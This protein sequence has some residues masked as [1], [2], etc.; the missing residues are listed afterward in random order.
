MPSSPRTPTRPRRRAAR[1]CQTPRPPRSSARRRCPYTRRFPARRWS[2]TAA[3]AA[4][5]AASLRELCFTGARALARLLRARKVSAAELMQAFIAQIERVNPRVNAI[6]TFVPEQAL[7][8]AR[9]LDRRKSWDAPLAGLPIAYKDLVPTKG[10]RTTF[11]SAIYADQV[12]A[13]N[14]LLVERL[15]AVGAITIGKTNT[16]EFG[17]G[18]QTFNA[19]FGTTRN[20]YD[21]SKTCGGSSGGA[22]VAVACG[23]LPFADGSELAASLRNPGNFCN[24]ACFRPTPGLVPNLPAVNGWQTLS[25]AGPMGRTVQDTAFLLSAMAGPDPRSPVSIAE[26]G[27]LFNR[28]LKRSFRKVRVA[29]SRDLGGLPVEP[30]V[31]A[32]LE[33]QRKIFKQLGCVVEDAEP[34]LAPATEAF[35][36]LRALGFLDRLPLLRKHRDKLKDTV[37][38]NI[39]AGLKLTGEQIARG[40]ELRTQVFHRMRTFLGKYDFLLCPV[41]QVVPFSVDQ[42]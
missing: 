21:L 12:P 18:S 40:N 38:W 23:M 7:K 14:H 26:P 27:T 1:C 3:A 24:V 33:R 11:G 39:E 35:H 13:E 34:D 16:P 17:A 20:P 42:P 25:T 5:G 29:W 41:N 15:S 37:I 19:V 9:A 2:S 32:V 4:P 10:I 31:T 8:A 28:P 30:A 22:A 6:V 36:T